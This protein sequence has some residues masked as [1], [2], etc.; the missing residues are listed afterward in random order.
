MF[1]KREQI[2]TIYTRTSKL[3]VEHNY[4]RNKTVL[5]FRC[6]NC[7]EIFTRDAKLVDPRRTSNNFF[8]VCSN[9]DPKRFAQKKGVERRQVWDM[10]V[11]TDLPVGKY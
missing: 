11:S 2:E 4:K 1:I 10:H 6:D 5:V 9:C 3:G 7:D 8:H